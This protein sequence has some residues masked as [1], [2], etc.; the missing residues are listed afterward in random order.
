MKCFYSNS[1]IMVTYISIKKF[2]SVNFDNLS[3]EYIFNPLSN[4][5]LKYFRYFNFTPNQITYLSALSGLLSLGFFIHSK[6]FVTTIFYFLSYLFDCVD[7]RYARKY[8]M[9]SNYGM[10]I[11]Q[12]TDVIVN[13]PILFLL[14]IRLLNKLY[15]V[16]IILL[17]TMTYLLSLSFSLNEAYECIIK[18]NHDDFYNIKKYSIID[19]GENCYVFLYNIFLFINKNL[20]ERYHKYI[21]NQQDIHG[22]DVLLKKNIVHQ[23]CEFFK[24]FGTGNYCMFIILMILNC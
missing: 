22:Y 7:G 17:L 12:V 21:T 13:I 3:D 20:Y 8:N 6:L 11:D 15:I 16:K 18:N 2:G 9:T 24:E 23:S 19:S 5:L 14:L 10:M 4:K 1:K